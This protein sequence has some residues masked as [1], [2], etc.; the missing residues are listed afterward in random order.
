MTTLCPTCGNYVPPCEIRV[1]I[2]NHR[3]IHRGQVVKLTPNQAIVLH[4][5]A[6]TWPHNAHRDRISYALWGGAQGPGNELNV[7]G[8]TISQLRRRIE[9]LGLAI[10]AERDSGY[11]LRIAP[12]V[13]EVAA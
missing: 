5:L 6:K 8:S 13:A 10:E 12:K 7:I 11:G 4:L 1:D 2:D 3:V 9:P